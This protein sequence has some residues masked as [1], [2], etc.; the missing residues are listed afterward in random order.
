MSADD[1]GDEALGQSDQERISDAIHA[2]TERRALIEQT[3]GML[4]FVYGIDANDA[5]ELLRWQSQ[6]HNVKLRLIA[7]QISKDLVELSRV[8]RPARRSAVDGVMLTAHQ[9]IAHVA[10]RQ[11]NGQ[12]KTDE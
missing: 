5:F 4:M 10:A 12:S 6:Q 1:P 3:K 2:I 7:E 9:R 11:M 8:N